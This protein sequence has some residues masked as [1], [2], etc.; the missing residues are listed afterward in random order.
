MPDVAVH[1]AFGNE[2]LSSLPPAVRDS[3][4]QEPYRFALFGPDLWFMYRPWQRREGRGRRMHTTRTGD[5]LLALVRRLGVS[6]C[7]AE[8]FSYLSGFLCHYALDSLT[9]PYIVYV[10]T[11]EHFFPRSHMSL[12][13]ALDALE[14][15]RDGLWGSS[16]PITGHYYPSMRLPD[17]LREDLDAVFEDTY[18]WKNCWKALNASCRRYRA[19]YRIMEHPRGLAARFTRLTKIPVFR[20]LV[21][22]ESHFHDLDPENTAHRPWFNPFDPSRRS[23]ESFPELRE[24]ARRRAVDLIVAVWNFARL[25]RGTEE[26]LAALIG[27]DSYLSGLPWDD[28]RNGG[29]SSLLPPGRKE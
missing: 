1:A 7:P 9:H 3:L 27:S 25:G 19:C 21:Y 22:S 28:P 13:H 24:K 14:M 29:V 15:Q 17:C 8:L 12:E 11:K 20:S 6:A 4:V 23:S 10:T 16:H 18:G 5:F 26:T 2:V